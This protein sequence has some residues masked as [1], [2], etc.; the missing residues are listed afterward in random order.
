MTK[1]RHSLAA[2]LAIVML[3]TAAQAELSFMRASYSLGQWMTPRRIIAGW[4]PPWKS[5]VPNWP[6]VSRMAKAHNARAQ[7]AYAMR[8]EHS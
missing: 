2:T 6:A 4:I 8:P 7:A 5:L 1:R 3:T